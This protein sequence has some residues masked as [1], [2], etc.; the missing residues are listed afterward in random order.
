MEAQYIKSYRAVG[1]TYDKQ[2]IN[3][4]WQLLRKAGFRKAGF[5][6]LH[7]GALCSPVPRHK[8]MALNDRNFTPIR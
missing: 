2:H 7:E 4:G 3:A 5:H 6:A 8:C 1:A